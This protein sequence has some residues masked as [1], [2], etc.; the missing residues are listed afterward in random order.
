ML[1]V[2]VDMTSIP[3]IPYGGNS[4]RIPVNLLYAPDIGF[5][6]ILGFLE[7]YPGVQFESREVTFVAG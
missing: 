7:N 2:R 3:E 5:D 6:I 4:L 1:D